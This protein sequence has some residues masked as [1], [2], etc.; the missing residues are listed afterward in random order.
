M[1]RPTYEE[2]VKSCYST[3]GDTYFNDYYGPNAPYPPVHT[4][5]LKALIASAG[6]RRVLDAGCGPA[7]FLRELLKQDLDLYGFD[8]TPEMVTEAK[9]VMAEGG[10]PSDH[11]W[12][13]S[14]LSPDSFRSPEGSPAAYDAAVC[15]GVLPHIAEDAEPQVFK[16]LHDSVRPGGLVVVEARNQLFSL[17]SLNYYSYHFMLDELIRVDRLSERAGPLAAKILEL[18][19]EMAKHFRTDLPTTRTGKRAEPG[20]DEV[21]SRTHNPLVLKDRFADAGFADV[22][23]HFYH[24]HSLP[25]MYGAAV[26]ELFRAESVAMEDPKDWRGHFMASAFL[27][28]GRRR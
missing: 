5:L 23:L 22:Q 20:Y 9:R 16:S 25:P 10:V 12:E 17:F 3:W 4:A 7:S 6:A 15:I 24:Y 26:P 18:K 11:I 21:L 14:V 27:L 2:S 19:E 13:G 28:S 8:L 1:P